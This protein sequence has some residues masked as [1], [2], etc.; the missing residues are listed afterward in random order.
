MRIAEERAPGVS[1]P[2]KICTPFGKCVPAG[3]VH[4]KSFFLKQERT[5][6]NI[7]ELG[8]GCGSTFCGISLGFYLGSQLG[9]IGWPLGV[10]SGFFLPL[11]F[12]K[13]ASFVIWGRS[14]SYGKSSRRPN[15]F[16]EITMVCITLIIW[17]AMVYFSGKLMLNV[18]DT[19]H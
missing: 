13:S 17:L 2:T 5:I 7:V 14:Y 15:T 12:L 19:K 16:F 8:I 11:L 9:I 6:M 18:I 3:P 1:A 10:L 4:K